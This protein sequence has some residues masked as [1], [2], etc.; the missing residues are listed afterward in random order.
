MF[1]FAHLAGLLEPL[2][3]LPAFLVVLWA[4]FNSLRGR[5]GERHDNP[6]GEP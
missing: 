5:G 1:V 4:M 2:A 6:R 3:F